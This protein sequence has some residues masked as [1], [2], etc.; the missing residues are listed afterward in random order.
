MGYLDGL[1]IVTAAKPAN[2]PPILYKRN[3][4]IEKL[5]TQ[6]ECIRA[7]SEGKEHFVTYTKISKG[8]DGEKLQSQQ[9]KKVRPW[10]YRSSDGKIVMEIKYAN[11]R[12]E[13]A[14]GKT[15]IEV[16][17]LNAL[18]PALQIIIKAIEEGEL[19]GTI[20]SISS[21]FRA[22]LTK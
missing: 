16:E 17:N 11:K 8:D 21:N 6:I 9:V 15:G 19:D 1:K 20:N 2:I 22:T 4:L 5:Q 3:R 10:W 13:L 12:I 7:R 14:K 18:I